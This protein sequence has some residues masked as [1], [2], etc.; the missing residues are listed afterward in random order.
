MNN[1]YINVYKHSPTG[2]SDNPTNRG[3]DGMLVSENGS[4]TEPVDVTLNAADEDSQIIKLALRCQTGYINS[5]NAVIEIQNDPQNHWS[6]CLTQ[7]GEFDT[8]ITVSG[9]FS[10]NTIFWAKASSEASE[11]PTVEETS[12]FKVTVPI[13]PA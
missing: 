7:D 13:V 4:M 8:V 5:G 6:L 1:S 12:P 3:V 2:E 10:T 9:D 11:L